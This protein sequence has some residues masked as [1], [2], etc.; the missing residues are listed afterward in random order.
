MNW[1]HGRGFITYEVDFGT[2]NVPTRPEPLL[3]WVLHIKQSLA[4]R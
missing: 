2:Q 1:A 4:K 3:L